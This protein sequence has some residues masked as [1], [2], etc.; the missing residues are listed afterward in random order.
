MVT[1]R[2]FIVRAMQVLLTGGTGFLGGLLRKALEARGDDVRVVSRRE[3][4]GV[5]RWEEVDD[6]AAH[7]DAVVH[8]A[9][10]PIAAGRW[11]AERWERIRASRVD[12]TARIARA[13][14][15]SGRRRVLV[16]A[17]AVGIYGMRRDDVVCDEA[18]PPG[19]D[20]VARLCVGWEAAAD[21]AR[22]AGI[23][24]VH[25]RF[26]I[27]LGAG[28]GALA[29]MVKAF[30]WFVGGPVGGGTQWLSWVHAHDVVRALLLLLDREELAGPYNIVAPEPVTMNDLARAIGHALGRPSAMRVPGFAVRALFG[31]GLADALLTGQRVAPRRLVD[32]GFAFEFPRLDQA[33]A[34]LL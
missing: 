6:A 8:L 28:G 11:T 2:R 29:P 4:P 34:D 21:P 22:G 5:V 25:P 32:A 27:A 10:E 12:T 15:G 26:G 23:R 30:R 19:E 24:V 20:A 17:S 18:T 3:A 33:L 16:S 13:M 14:A 31:E 9:G 1:I 7:A